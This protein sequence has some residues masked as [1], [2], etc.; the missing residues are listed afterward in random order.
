MRNVRRGSGGG[1]DVLSEVVRRAGPVLDPRDVFGGRCRD[2]AAIH[3]CRMAIGLSN[4][5][6]PA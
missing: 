2:K 4:E 1:M 5:G 6:A 3:G